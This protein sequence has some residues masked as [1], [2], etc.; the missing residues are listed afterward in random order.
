[1]QTDPKKKNLRDWKEVVKTT[2]S[3]RQLTG[4]PERTSGA[5]RDGGQPNL[6]RRV[7]RAAGAIFAMETSR[8]RSYVKRM[9][10]GRTGS[11]LHF[12]AF[13][14]DWRQLRARIFDFMI[15]RGKAAGTAPGL[16][17]RPH[18]SPKRCC[19][20]CGSPYVRP[21][22]PRRLRDL[23]FR[24][25]GRKPYRCQ[26][27]FLRFFRSDPISGRTLGPARK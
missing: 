12:A 25:L 20:L 15:R 2:D 14:P 11:K 18:A 13:A 3:L 4:S 24:I 1:V 9:I 5:R 6:A 22:R 8:F 10:I 21:S 19:P 27:C 26:S 23:H 17:H 16:S 7:L